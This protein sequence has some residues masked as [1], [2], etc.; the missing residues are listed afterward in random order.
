MMSDRRTENR[1]CHLG[2]HNNWPIF[3]IMALYKYFILL[4]LLLKVHYANIGAGWNY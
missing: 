3:V 4:L 2:L 1:N